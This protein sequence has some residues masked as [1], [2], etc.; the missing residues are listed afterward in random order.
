MA[1]SLSIPKRE[2]WKQVS[3]TVVMGSVTPQGNN[4]FVCVISIMMNM[5]NVHYE[6]KK[7][8]LA[9]DSN[10]TWSPLACSQNERLYL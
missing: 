6:K 4:G 10:I 8:F 9:K 1:T 5:V 2:D 7:T 3:V